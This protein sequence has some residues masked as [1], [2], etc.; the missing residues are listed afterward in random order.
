MDKSNLE[1]NVPF[2]VVKD[3][4]TNLL[5]ETIKINEKVEDLVSAIEKNTNL[6]D[7]AYY[8]ELAQD[9]D[10]HVNLYMGYH[11]SVIKKFNNELFKNTTCM[12]FIAM[13]AHTEK[14]DIIQEIENNAIKN[15]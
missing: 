12:E 11:T 4:L 13:E 10:Y 9:L 15:I 3:H 5:K 6:P 1:I 7:R 8:L 2:S 14:E